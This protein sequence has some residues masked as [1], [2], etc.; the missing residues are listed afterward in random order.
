MK[1]RATC[2]PPTFT[3]TQQHRFHLSS[4]S[5]GQKKNGNL[6]STAEEK[7]EEKHEADCFCPKG[8]SCDISLRKDDA[9]ANSKVALGEQALM[10][11]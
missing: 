6:C 4:Y 9:K 8:S 2:H 10:S 11:L 7:W 1:I 3:S 5:H